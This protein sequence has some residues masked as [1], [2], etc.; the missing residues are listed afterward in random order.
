ME[1][2]N[3]LWDDLFTPTSLLSRH[4][5]PLWMGIKTRLA[6]C[7]MRSGRRFGKIPL[8]LRPPPTAAPIFLLRRDSL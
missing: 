6:L 4:P 8:R 2:P 3:G 7:P 1:R 5:I